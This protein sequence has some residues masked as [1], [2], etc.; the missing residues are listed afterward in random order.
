MVLLSES[1]IAIKYT[2]NFYL[3]KFQQ[4][5]LASRWRYWLPIAGRVKAK[6]SVNS[7]LPFLPLYSTFQALAWPYVVLKLTVSHFL[8]FTYDV[9]SAYQGFPGG[10]DK[11]SACSAGDLGSIL[12]SGRSPR[13]GNGYPLQYSC[14]ENTM[15]RGAWQA[16]V[17]CVAKSRIQLS[18][19]TF[20]L[21]LSKYFNSWCSQ[22]ILILS[23]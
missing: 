22:N 19:F 23:P 13:E 21:V 17:H 14:L 18:N 3:R 9:P 1:S 2:R 11:K 20:C 4:V 7:L 6:G 15:D 8:Y 16:T 10:S 12:G 5:S